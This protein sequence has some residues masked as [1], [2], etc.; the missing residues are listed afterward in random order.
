MTK[1]YHKVSISSDFLTSVYVHGTHRGWA[2]LWLRRW[3]IYLQCRRP[4]FDPGVGKIPWRRERLPTLVFWPREFHRQRSLVDESM[5]SQKS[6]TWPSDSHFH[7]GISLDWVK[8]QNIWFLIIQWLWGWKGFSVARSLKCTG[9]NPKACCLGW[10]RIPWVNRQLCKL[11]VSKPEGVQAFFLSE[12][13][14]TETNSILLVIS[15]PVL[16]PSYSTWLTTDQGENLEGH[17]KLFRS[18]GPQSL[19]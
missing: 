9:C 10:P 14:M 6:G 17:V 3:K 18:Q 4:G 13:R 19:K 16:P 15:G 12:E 1:V 8:Q 5:G 11:D 2:S 7:T